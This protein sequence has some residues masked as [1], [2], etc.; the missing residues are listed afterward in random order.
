[1]DK[2]LL[3]ER[4][5]ELVMG[6]F[7]YNGRKLPKGFNK[8]IMDSVEKALIVFVLERL[9][10]N[11]VRAAEILGMNR[12]TLRKKI[13][14]YGINVRSYVTRDSGT[15]RLAKQRVKEQQRREN[16]EMAYVSANNLAVGGRA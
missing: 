10:G 7:P 8:P 16:M 6:F 9:G 12:N 4:V 11:Q 14:L 15:V 13:M 5:A 1:M 3:E 2:Q